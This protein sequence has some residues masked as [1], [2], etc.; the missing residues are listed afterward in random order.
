MYCGVWRW[1]GKGTGQDKQE[2]DI[3]G[4]P[5]SGPAATLPCPGP[6]PEL[7]L[8]APSGGRT[9]RPLTHLPAP[10]MV[11]ALIHCSPGHF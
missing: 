10:Q 9:N 11:K 7:C 6:V 3:P 5:S 4:L 1:P 8:Y 2:A